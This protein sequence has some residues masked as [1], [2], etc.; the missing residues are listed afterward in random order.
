MPMPRRFRVTDDLQVGAYLLL[1]AG[2]EVYEHMVPRRTEPG[3]GEIA[4]TFEPDGGGPAIPVP[5]DAIEEI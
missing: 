4:V 1:P 3:P 2:T 5:T